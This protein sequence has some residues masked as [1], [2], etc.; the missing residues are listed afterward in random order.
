MFLGVCGSLRKDSLHRALLA[1]MEAMAPPAVAWNNTFDIASLPHFRPDVDP[2]R[3]G[4]VAEFRQLV[5]SASGTVLSVPEYAHSIPG[6]FKNAMDWLVSGVEFMQMPV[7][8]VSPYRKGERSRDHLVQVLSA[9]S[10]NVCQPASFVLDIDNWNGFSRQ[11]PL[12]EVAK[13]R[14][15]IEALHRVARSPLHAGVNLSS[16]S[17]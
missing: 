9:M 6:T 13:I 10:A 8:I 16:S 12:A 7:A 3:I 1:A 15:A 17:G 5:A 11:L 2:S 4:S 14:S